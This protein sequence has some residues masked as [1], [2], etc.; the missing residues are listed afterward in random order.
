MSPLG[1]TLCLLEGLSS[2][3]LGSFLF[4]PLPFLNCASTSDGNLNFTILLR[5]AFGWLCLEGTGV[6]RGAG[7]EV[8]DRD[9]GAGAALG[10]GG[11]T[12]GRD[13]AGVEGRELGAEDPGTV[14]VLILIL[15]P[16]EG[17]GECIGDGA[18]MALGTL[19]GVGFGRGGA[20]AGAGVVVAGIGAGACETLGGKIG[21]LMTGT[22][23]GSFFGGDT[24]GGLEV[25]GGSTEDFC[26]MAGGC[27]AGDAFR[28]GGADI[29]AGE[30]CLIGG[31]KVGCA[32]DRADG[33]G[34]D[35]LLDMLDLLSLSDNLVVFGG[36]AAFGCATFNGTTGAGSG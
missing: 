23:V 33:G 3:P 10:R 18:E 19:T 31:E 7:V 17:I 22:G 4:L 27:G 1:S 35:A 11:G 16:E 6:G 13:G 30:A 14:L 36:A 9:G 2:P 5:L 15:G 21:V 24:A 32:L 34:E 8:A 26:S 12:L 20:G 25:F 28:E 29:G